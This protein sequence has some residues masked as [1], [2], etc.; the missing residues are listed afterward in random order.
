MAKQIKFE[1]IYG[2]WLFAIPIKAAPGILLL[3]DAPT[4]GFME[5]SLAETLDGDRYAIGETAE[6]AVE[7]LDAGLR[8][9]ALRKKL[10]GR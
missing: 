10:S 3:P 4:Y 5:Y 1:F 7:C 2:R 9:D 8:L 6:G